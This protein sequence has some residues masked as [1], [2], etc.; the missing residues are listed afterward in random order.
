MLLLSPDEKLAHKD[1]RLWSLG[2]AEIGP[3]RA[4]AFATCR[5]PYLVRLLQGDVIAN[6]IS[7]NAGAS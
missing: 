3:A 5:I 7:A 4:D 2:L 1:K 6:V